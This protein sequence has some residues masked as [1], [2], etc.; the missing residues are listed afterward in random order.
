[1]GQATWSERTRMSVEFLV[2]PGLH[3]LVAV[4]GIVTGFVI[5]ED[6]D[7]LVARGAF[8]GGLLVAST[9][10]LV[11]AG[12]RLDRRRADASRGPTPAK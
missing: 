10:L 12:F 2:H 3:V 1:M 6:D 9:I 5:Y 7:R 4:V 11:A 8:A